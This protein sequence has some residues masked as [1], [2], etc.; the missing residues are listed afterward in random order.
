M[1]YLR[2]PAPKI[3]QN[4][5]RYFW[6]LEGEA[7]EAK[8]YIHR[9]M[10]D[11]GAELIFHYS[12][13]FKELGAGRFETSSSVSEFSAQTRTVRRFSSTDS[14]G[15][16]GA[17]LFPFALTDLFKISVKEVLGQK[18]PPEDLLGKEGKELSASILSAE[19][20]EAR[21]DLLI[22]YLIKKLP[23]QKASTQG[24]QTSV[25][26]LIKSSGR[27]KVSDLADLS[28]L[29]IRQFER[30]FKQSTGFTPITFSRILR[31][32]S[33]LKYYP[34]RQGSLT[35]IAYASGYYDQSHFI[36]DFKEFSGHNPKSFFSG[37]AESLEWRSS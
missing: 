16:L 22:S 6:V 24:I 15:I 11:V 28:C 20:H 19:K 37:K 7:T 2:I 25:H 36:R 17:Y 21:L 31:F 13:V 14:F 5:V 34:Y 29:S 30:R 3:L 12:G 27:T 32:Q 10:A 23:F 26:K 1:K 18:I 33:T 8:P 4:Y 9:T 35:D